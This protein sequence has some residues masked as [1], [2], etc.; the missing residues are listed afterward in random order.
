MK[1][2]RLCSTME[3][4]GL[5]EYINADQD[6]DENG[7][8]N[9]MN[10]LMQE[11]PIFKRASLMNNSH[12]SITLLARC[13]KCCVICAIASTVIIIALILSLVLIFVLG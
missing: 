2:N 9:A 7:I 11:K 1:L 3:I 5:Q 8:N 4:L 10:Q 13:D 6:E 12:A